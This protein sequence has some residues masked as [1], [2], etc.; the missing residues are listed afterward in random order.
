MNATRAKRGF[1]LVD[2][3]VVIVIMAVFVGCIPSALNF[4]HETERRAG[5]MNRQKMIALAFHNHLSTY[6]VFPPSASLAKAPDGNA[7]T[8][9]GWSLMVRLLPFMDHDS[10]YKTLPAKGDPEDA[11]KPAIVVAM[12]TQLKEFLCPS[13]PRGRIPPSNCRASPT[14]RRWARPP[15]TAS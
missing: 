2:L 6:G 12:N 3:I 5:C 4:S 11:T 8:V 7:Q 14:T 1:T 10:L 13:G 9:G 15:A